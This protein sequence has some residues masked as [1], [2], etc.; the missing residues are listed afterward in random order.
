MTSACMLQTFD[1][2]SLFVRWA[3]SIPLV[4]EA[5]IMHHAAEKTMRRCHKT[6]LQNFVSRKKEIHSADDASW[7]LSVSS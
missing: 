5:G 4:C 6:R 3:K 2:K 1:C 7:A